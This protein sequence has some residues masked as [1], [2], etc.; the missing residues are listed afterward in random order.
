MPQKYRVEGLLVVSL[1]VTLDKIREING[2][3]AIDEVNNLQHQ[4]NF[5]VPVFKEILR[6]VDIFRL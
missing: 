3:A 1:A 4:D 2:S 6:A 5:N